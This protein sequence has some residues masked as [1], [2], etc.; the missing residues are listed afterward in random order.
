MTDLASAIAGIPSGNANMRIGKV[1]AFN[2]GSVSVNVGGGSLVSASYLLSPYYRPVL[3]DPV[4]L[5]STGATWVILGTV[6]GTPANNAV[7]NY[8]FESG[9]LSGA[10]NNWQLKVG[11]SGAGTP[12]L[13]QEAVGFF[14]DEIDGPL[15]AQVLLTSTGA[16]TS[17]VWVLS[18]PI[19]V[20]PG[21]AWAASVHVRGIA[22]YA[23]AGNASANCFLNL[24]WYADAVT[25]TAASVYSVNGAVLA[26]EYGWR[27]MFT[28]NQPSGAIVPGGAN[29]LR[30][31][32][33]T[34]FQPTAAASNIYVQ[35]DRVVARKILNA[36]GSLVL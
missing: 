20:T 31:Q 27:Q 11:S 36:D 1:V 14:G 28:A 19:P 23:I 9:V 26:Q 35:W 16:G 34:R 3:G 33:E 17:D 8:S 30:I 32:L 6:S 18:D 5:V 7:T 25:T 21:E 15:A 10:I 4:V 24:G 29:F 2:A 12:V 13:T 22:Y